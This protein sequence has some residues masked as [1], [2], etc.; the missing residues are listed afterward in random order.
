M[1]R[2]AACLDAAAGG[3]SGKDGLPSASGDEAWTVHAGHY[4]YVYSVVTHASS[5]G[6]VTVFSGGGDGIILVWTIAGDGSVCCHGNHRLS[7]HSGAIFDLLVVG[8]DLWSCSQDR[9]M[10]VWDVDTLHCKRVIAAHKVLLPLWLLLLAAPDDPL[11]PTGR[12][13]VPVQCRRA[14]QWRLPEHRLLRFCR[15]HG[16]ALGR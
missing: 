6:S 10:R 13:A 14:R 15:S 3:G 9:S 1:K 16:A 4:G 7:G 8:Q 12:G 5:D 2:K 11:C